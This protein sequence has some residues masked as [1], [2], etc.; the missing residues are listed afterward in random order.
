MHYWRHKNYPGEGPKV[1][2][3]VIGNLLK[4]GAHPNPDHPANKL[5]E[6][7]SVFCKTAA[8]VVT[9]NTN[10]LKSTIIVEQSQPEEIL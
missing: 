5:D 3:D 1:A 6:S 8:E 2:F 4:E 10:Q 9:L 7:L